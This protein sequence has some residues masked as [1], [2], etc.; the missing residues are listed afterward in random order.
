MISTDFILGYGAGKAAGGGGAGKPLILRPDAELVKSWS[1]DKYIVADEGV[2]IPPYQSSA[3]TLLNA[4]TIE[5]VSADRVSYTYEILVTGLAT[6]K[7]ADGQT[8]SV[9]QAF[10]GTVILD[11]LVTLPEGAVNKGDVVTDAMSI[12]IPDTLY[13][14]CVT[15]TGTGW[16]VNATLSGANFARSSYVFGS[17]EITIK[18]PL[19]QL[20]GGTYMP[21][22]TWGAL[23]D[24]RYQYKIELY[25]TPNISWDSNGLTVAQA[26]A[27]VIKGYNSPNGKLT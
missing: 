5:D 8:P 7:Y 27:K 18:S 2:T 23:S 11:E 13:R 3:A 12:S 15:N 21:Q 17:S 4:Q 14:F 25:R 10:G 6:P 1:Y 20:T 26:L 24:I 9:I 22:A 19:L 16:R